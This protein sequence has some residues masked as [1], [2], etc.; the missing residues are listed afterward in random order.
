MKPLTIKDYSLVT[1]TFIDANPTGSTFTFLYILSVNH[2][3]YYGTMLV[4][5][6]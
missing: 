5:L 4:G 6:N 2:L 3:N 1:V